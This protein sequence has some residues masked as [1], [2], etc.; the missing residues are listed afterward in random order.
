VS[1][2]LIGIDVG[3]TNVKTA[4]YQADGMPLADAARPLTVQQ[5]QPGWSEYDA[6]ALFAETA[7]T[8]RDVCAQIDTSQVAAVSISSMAE[9][10]VPIDADG[11][12]LRPAIAWH[13]NR[14]QAQAQWWREAVGDEAVYAICGL[15]ILPIFGIHKLMW[16]REHEADLFKQIDTW[17]NVADYVAFRLCGT[18]V[19]NLS[20]AS[21]MMALDLQK[22][23]W[24]QVLLSTCGIDATYLGELVASGQQIGTVHAEASAQTGL[25][26]GT[27][28]VAGGMD[29]PCG[30]L[31]LG[32]HQQGDVLDSM[33]TSESI[34]TVLDQPLLTADMAHSGYQQ[35]IHV[36]PERYACNGG[37][38]TSGAAIEWLRQLLPMLSDTSYDK[39]DELGEAVP[40]GSDGVY[41]LPHL[42]IASPPHVDD[43]SRGAFIGLTNRSQPAHLT[44][45]VLEGL[46]YEAR[47]SLDGMRQRLGIEVQ[48]VRAIGGGTRNTLLMQIKANVY[49]HTVAISHV[50]E[51]STLGA[52]MLAGIGSGVFA[53]FADANLAMTPSY[54][55]VQP[56]QPLQTLYDQRY[57]QVYRHMYRTLSQ[58]HH[59]IANSERIV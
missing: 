58:L 49:G 59:A 26:S 57:T 54:E 33:G 52:A 6:E 34:F 48:H 25:T 35:G 56:Q 36:N 29:H 5:P 44:R 40:A 19:T 42:R 23:Q 21:R 4:A 11:K 24:S 2:I 10:A 3:T 30:A 1:D 43:R 41:F 45:A 31:A 51:A 15:P 22:R 7:A 18:R 9:T 14:T 20:L 32:I 39:L 38:Y 37:L 55:H 16:M 28:V 47:Y 53:S 12:P 27:P 13:D 46:A 8:V 17:L 50:D